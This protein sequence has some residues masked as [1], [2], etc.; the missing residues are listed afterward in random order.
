MT[1]EEIKRRKLKR[2]KEV[3]YGHNHLKE[4]VYRYALYI[5]HHVDSQGL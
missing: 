1:G 5:H 2:H 3:S 4:P